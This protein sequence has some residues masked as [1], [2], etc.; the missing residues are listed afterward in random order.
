[1]WSDTLLI[2]FISVCTALLGEGLTYVLVYRTEKYI[3]LKNEVEKASKKRKF[4]KTWKPNLRKLTKTN[5]QLKNARNIR[6]KTTNPR[7]RRLNVMKKS[8]RTT[9]GTF[10]WWKWKVCLPQVSPSQLCLACSTR[11]LTEKLLLV[12]HLLQFLGFKDWVTEIWAE[13]ITQN[14]HS[15]SCTFCV[16][17]QFVRI[18]RNCWD[19]LLQ[20]LPAN[21]EIPCSLLHQDNL[22]NFVK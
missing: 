14:A 3:K 19:L 22:D 17:C 2:L 16:Q 1:M 21:K 8:L 9:T 4:Y 10:P 7:K 18:F 11:S 12:C 13:K 20:E 6:T 15:F 5:F